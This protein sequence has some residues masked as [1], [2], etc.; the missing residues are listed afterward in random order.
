MLRVDC[1]EMSRDEELALA[2]SISDELSGTALAL[3]SDGKV[4][5]DQLSGEALTVE[6]LK[7][8]VFRFVSKRKDASLYSLEVS[9]SD[10]IVHTPD[11]VKGMHRHTPNELPPN[12]MKCPFC[13]FV[14]PYEELY[15]VHTRSHGFT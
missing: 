7:A 13:S 6:E 14:T 2:S 12:M 11:P 5:I 15:Q 9:G 3:V 10:I 1:S 8:A 4:I